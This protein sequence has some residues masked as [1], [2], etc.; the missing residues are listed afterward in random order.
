M[1]LKYSYRPQADVV[2]FGTTQNALARWLDQQKRAQAQF[3]AAQQPLQQ[4]VQMFQPGGGYGRGQ[5]TLLREEARRTKAEATARQV[6]SGMSSGSLATGTAMR[7]ERDLATGLAGVEDV[8][9]QFLNRALQAL[10]GLQAGQA[11][12][13]AQI[14]DPTFAPTLGYLASRFGQVGQLNQ[15][16]GAGRR[17]PSTPLPSIQIARPSATTPTQTKIGIGSR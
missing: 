17:R 2:G 4:A 5:Q 14:S 11:Q 12:T 1:A 6:A 15:A 3:T 8:R 13:T 9:T 16:A 10:S 7:T